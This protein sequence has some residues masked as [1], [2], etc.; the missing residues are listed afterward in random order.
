MPLIHF[1]IHFYII[2][3]FFALFLLF[4]KVLSLRKYNECIMFHLDFIIDS[5]CHFFGDGYSNTF[6][7]FWKTIAYFGTKMEIFDDLDA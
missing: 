2:M 6:S 3:P 1:C 5:K 7:V 4:S